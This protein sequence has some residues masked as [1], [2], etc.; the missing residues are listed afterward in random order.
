MLR[1]RDENRVVGLIDQLLAHLESHDFPSDFL[2]RI[3]LRRVEHMYYKLDI[4][5]LR[6]IRDQ[7]KT[8]EEKRAA[9]EAKDKE[10][11]SHAG[12]T[13]QEE[14]V[15]IPSDAGK[16]EK[17]HRDSEGSEKERESVLM[18]DKLCKF[19][20]AKAADRIRTRAML[21][22]IYHHALH[23]RWYQ[24]RDLMLISHLQET[25]QHSDIPTQVGFPPIVNVAAAVLVAVNLSVTI[26]FY[27][28]QFYT[29]RIME[30]LELRL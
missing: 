3:Y 14:P 22:Q 8:A 19:I 6:S 11:L 24:A 15:S 12:V 10:K 13:T 1:L 17:S 26:S 27:A 9:A 21:C 5:E 20:Y 16:D 28:T 7:I 23:D 18:L 2:C 29:F 4:Q 25:I 30:V